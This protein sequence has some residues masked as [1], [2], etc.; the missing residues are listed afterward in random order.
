MWRQHVAFDLMLMHI[1]TIKAHWNKRRAAKNSLAAVADA[2]ANELETVPT[3]VPL[4]SRSKPS[5]SLELGWRDVYDIA[6]RWRQISEVYFKKIHHMTL[7]SSFSH[8]SFTPFFCSQMIQFGGQTF[9]LQNNL[10]KGLAHIHPLSR[11]NI[12]YFHELYSID[13]SL[14]PNKRC[15]LLSYV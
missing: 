10:L 12:F 7:F 3:E 9:C 14:R 1:Q 6:V 13:F 4:H 15:S 2:N 5:S 11:V 8:L